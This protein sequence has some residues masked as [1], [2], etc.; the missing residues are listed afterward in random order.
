M[1]DEEP[2]PNGS[3]THRRT[4]TAEVTDAVTEGME[5]VGKLA[6]QQV[7]V[8]FA[9]VALCFICS[10]QAFQMFTDREDRRNIAR[11][12]QDAAAAQIRESNAQSE[13]T[14][15]HCQNET[16]DLRTFFAEQNEKRL[17]FE[18]EERSKDRA[19]LQMMAARIQDIERA[20]GAKKEE[21]QGTVTRAPET[22]TP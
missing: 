4:R 20:I 21:D 8:L 2:K 15:Q 16:R 3:K 9:L 6:P 7:M 22:S 13:L 17:K 11:E 5:R 18:S 1:P 19:V 10:M 14:R 12:R